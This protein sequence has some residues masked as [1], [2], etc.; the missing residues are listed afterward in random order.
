MKDIDEVSHMFGV[1]QTTQETHGKALDK[2]CKEVEAARQD[3]R[4]NGASLEKVNERSDRHEEFI[5]KKVV[6][7]MEETKNITFA[8]RKL[9]AF[10]GTI[11]GIVGGAIATA[12]SKGFMGF[13]H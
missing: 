3:I 9:I 6:P 12:A 8:A 13:F 7:F 2:L 5:D 1:I 10:I 4:I 11:A